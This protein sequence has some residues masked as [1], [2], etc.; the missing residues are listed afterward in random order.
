MT[1][2]NVLDSLISDLRELMDKPKRSKSNHTRARGV[3]MK[4]IKECNNLRVSE[5]AARKA[6][7]VVKKAVVK[8]EVEEK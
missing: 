6:I 4:L 2:L 5:L 1:S 7:G 3:L 8:K